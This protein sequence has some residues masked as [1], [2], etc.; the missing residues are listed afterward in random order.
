MEESSQNLQQR[1]K[2]NHCRDLWQPSPIVRN[3]PVNS[4]GEPEY[5]ADLSEVC[6][7]TA[8]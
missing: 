1:V 7:S 4:K 3:M 6:D 2:K 8:H 5:V